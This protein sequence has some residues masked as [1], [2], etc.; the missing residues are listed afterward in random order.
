MNYILTYTVLRKGVKQWSSDFGQSCWLSG[1]WLFWATHVNRPLCSSFIFIFLLISLFF[2]EWVV[3][4]DSI[5][6]L[7]FI[8]KSPFLSFLFKNNMILSKRHELFSKPRGIYIYFSS[9]K[10]KVVLLYAFSN[11]WPAVYQST[12]EW[13]K[14]LYMI[15]RSVNKQRLNKSWECHKEKNISRYKRPVH[16]FTCYFIYYMLVYIIF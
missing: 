10:L 15:T 12:S 6:L 8:L 7:Y 11:P 1:V 5:L 13:I 16:S 4:W 9:V 14:T 2:L 3:T